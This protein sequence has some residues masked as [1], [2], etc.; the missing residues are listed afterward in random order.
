MNN[1]N[2]KPVAIAILEIM[3]TI[4][5]II[6]ALMIVVLINMVILKIV[7]LLIAITEIIAAISP[8]VIRIVIPHNINSNISNEKITVIKSIATVKVPIIVIVG[9]Q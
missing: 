2:N 9:K 4:V 8:I 5:T 7:L 6:L 3:I 1:N